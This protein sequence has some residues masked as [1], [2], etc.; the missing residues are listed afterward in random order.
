MS[1][2]SEQR[3][4][5]TLLTNQIR[6]K[7]ISTSSLAKMSEERVKRFK[8]RS[9]KER[10]DSIKIEP[11]RKL[12]KRAFDEAETSHLLA[13][14]ERGREFNKS[15]IYTGFV[16]SIEPISQSLV[17]ILHHKKKIFQ[18]FVTSISKHDV[19]SLEPLLEALA[20]FCHDLGP[21]F[22]EFYEDAILLIKEAALN[23]TEPTA[24]EAEFNCLAFIFKYLSRFLS[25]DLLQTFRLLFPLFGAK[26]HVCRFTAEA[27][28]FLIRKSSP[29][30]LKKVTSYAFESLKEDS[31]TMK[32]VVICYSEAISTTQ[33]SIHSKSESIIQCLLDQ[34]DESYA[35]GVLGDV[36]VQVIAHAS[37]E[38]V[39]DLYTLVL[40]NALA[41]LRDDREFFRSYLQILL[42]LMF[43]ESGAKITDWAVVTPYV[44]VI[45]E[46]SDIPDNTKELIVEVL[47]VFIRNCSSE[48]LMMF[49]SHLY[50]FAAAQLGHHFL[51][52]IKT[53]F[54][55]SEEK[56]K[57]FSGPYLQD[58]INKNHSK[59]GEHISLFIRDF[60]NSG[61][62][63]RSE[64]IGE[65]HVFFPS[66]STDLLFKE[67]DDL[68][69]QSSKDLYQ[70]YWRMVIISYAGA[71]NSNSLRNLLSK[72]DSFED[73]CQLKKHVLSQIIVSLEDIDVVNKY[74]TTLYTSLV[75]LRG[76]P[77]S[78]ELTE[79]YVLLFSSNLLSSDHNL[80]L[81][82][83]NVLRRFDV[84]PSLSDIIGKCAIIEEI[85]V[86][87]NTARDIQT[88]L[89]NLFTT[90]KNLDDKTTL[91]T[92][93]LYKFVFGLLSSKFSPI[94]QSIF[95]C[96]PV[97]DNYNQELLWSIIRVFIADDRETVDFAG[98]IADKESSTDSEFFSSDKRL[99]GIVDSVRNSISFYSDRQSSLLA[100]AEEQYGVKEYPQFMRGH[101]FKALR[102]LTRVADKFQKDVVSLLLDS[103]SN[104]TGSAVDADEDVDMDAAA[105][106]D[107]DIETPQSLVTA[108]SKGSKIYGKHLIE[109]LDLF[110]AW[111]KL[112]K[113]DR[114]DEIFKK[115]L[116][117]LSFKDLGVR[118]AALNVIFNFHNPAV[119]KFKDNL[120]NMLD[121]ITFRD[122]ITKLLSNNE[123][124]SIGVEDNDVVM[125]IVLRLLLGKI[126]TNDTSGH[127]K[128]FKAS[129]ILV[130][131]HLRASYIEKF[132]DIMSEAVDF[133]ERLD[134]IGP[135]SDGYLR[136]ATAYSR[137]LTKVIDTLGEKFKGT[138]LRIINPLLCTLLSAQASI[139][140]EEA[141]EED[142]VVSQTLARNVRQ[143][144]FKN[145]A[146]LFNL[147]SDFSW[148]K[149]FVVIY[150]KLLEPR[151]ASFEDENLQQ[152]TSL[153]SIITSWAKYKSYHELL[154][155][156]DLQPA[157]NAL[158]L[159]ANVNTKPAVL[160][161]VITF[162]LD[163]VKKINGKSAKYKDLVSLVSKTGF[164]HLPD[165][166]RNSSDLKVNV[167]CIE[168]LL[169]L[170]NQGYVDSQLRRTE[171][172]ALCTQLLE[173]P[174][175]QLSKDSRLQIFAL[176]K[177]LV[178]DFEGEFGEIQELWDTSSKHLKTLSDRF[179][180][181]QLIELFMEFG[182]KFSE[183]SEISKLIVNLNAFSARGMNEF[184][185]DVRLEAY[186][187]INDTRYA[188]LALF[189][190][191]PLLNNAL[192]FVSAETDLSIRG[193]A[194]YTLRRFVD[195]VNSNA[196]LLPPFKTL[197]LP[198]LRTNLR[199]KSE[200]VQTEYILLLSH[201]VKTITVLDD[202]ADMKVLLC[203]GDEEANFFNNINHIQLYRRQEAVTKLGQL[204]SQINGASVAHYILPMIEHYAYVEDEKFRNIGNDTIAAIEKLI[205]RVTYKQY[206]AIF[207]RYLSGLKETSATIRDSVKLVVTLSKAF[208]VNIKSPGDT[209]AGLPKDQ[210]KLSS[211]VELDMITPLSTVLNKR[212][213]ET[214]VQRTPLIE[215]LAS[216]IMCLSHEH[217]VSILPGTLTSICQILRSRADSIREAVRKH[218]ARASNIVGPKYTR[219]IIS[220]LKT[221]LARGF[222]VHVLGFTVHTILASMEFNHGDLDESADLLMYI[223]M[224]NLF[225]STGKEKEADGYKTTM[226]E[227]K[228]N[229]SNDIAEILVRHISLNKFESILRPLKMI[230]KERI[231]S[232]IQAKIDELIRRISLGL[233]KNDQLAD[234]DMLV[235]CY[236]I[237]ADSEAKIFEKKR[238]EFTESEMHFMVQLDAKPQMVV[239]E[240]KIH[241]EVMQRLSLDLLRTTLSKNEK[242]VNVSDLRG[243][244]PFFDIGLNSESEPV[245]ISVLRVLGFVI[246]LQF[247]DQ[248]DIFKTAARKCLNIIKGSPSTDSELVQACYKYLSS[249]LR[250]RE[251]LA[252]K[253]S[254]LGYLLVRIQS[255][256]N[257]TNKQGIAFN[258]IKA[259][260]SKHVM[261]PEVYD[262]MD[263]IREVMVTS[264]SKERRDTSRSIYYQFIMEY[265]QG[266]GRLE[267]QFTFLVD[268]L[269]YPAEA[270]KQSVMEFIHLILQK[271]GA[272]LLKTLSSSFFVGL[273]KVLISDTTARTKE[274]AV[275]L[276]TVIFE[277]QGMESFDKYISGWMNS[278]NSAL[279]RCSLQLYGIRL[280]SCGL[281]NKEL[282]DD[283]IDH[284]REVLE[285]SKNSSEVAVPWE[286]LY[287]VLNCL[288]S[289]LKIDASVVDEELLEDLISVLLFPHS[290]IRLSGNRLINVLMAKEGVLSSSNIQ[291]IAYRMFHQMRAPGCDKALTAEAIKFLMRSVLFWEAGSVEFD[292]SLNGSGEA[293]D[294]AEEEAE[295]E[296][297]EQSNLMMTEW[298]MNHASK[299]IR[300]HRSSQ[301]AKYSSIQLLAMAIQSLPLER[302]SELSETF[303][304]AL[305]AI[306]ENM[307]ENDDAD[308]IEL[309]N[310]AIECLK[311]LEDK[312][313]ISA[314]T[315]S[316]ANVRAEINKTRQERR[317]KR[318]RLAI[319]APDVAAR[320]R[321]RKNE[322][323]K[324]K[325]KH[326]KD[327]N[328]F[329]HTKK[330]RT[331][332]R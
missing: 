197:L 52:F 319:T 246:D 217:I 11:T 127:K 316:Y 302:L 67:L 15:A 249:I 63:S 92:N 161:Q 135:P 32:G 151:F 264:H 216:F 43:A 166:L 120:S 139:V 148:D 331:L 285:S 150:E 280:K 268:N 188:D 203:E 33:G 311:L 157:R 182:N 169:T 317:T 48:V 65:L 253:E 131:T 93:V 186:R 283:V 35:A 1:T 195:V 37:V 219:F 178:K 101:A 89:R 102:I 328:G 143:A 159:I 14:V 271:A 222:Q 192:F 250:H 45:F 306:H 167:N 62:L 240:T 322:K 258:F 307:K 83:L 133:T 118:K 122:E 290:W 298:A 44:E 141:A 189:E 164:D 47:T 312:V 12:Q 206:M 16:D 223:V 49:H 179:Q 213:E 134:D 58:F 214:I 323:A 332:R 273:A 221:A 256:I 193:N 114:S 277:K 155:I 303:I 191:M 145:L 220:E 181:Q 117:Y 23:T 227:V 279:L 299:I 183:C 296:D 111:K 325:R 294:E 248:V 97:V 233:L 232:K 241:T 2:G 158:L 59:Y 84:D 6:H 162:C 66:S 318:A 100:D 94:W 103:D 19:L 69:V 40:K 82:T 218:L 286:L 160:N 196:T 313:G 107:D 171:L 225:G 75:F 55:F 254:S 121:D 301:G 215:A 80:R 106:E 305:Y 198:T 74:S 29:E 3:D 201:I 276:I 77:Q 154:L 153:L 95:E 140:A 252:L 109:L 85:P 31:S 263:K 275:S 34:L 265:D 30:E 116:S 284:I 326:E 176:L 60:E 308:F 212:N 244:L 163:V 115:C 125:D 207:K 146:L 289:I 236:E 168:L 330:K 329:Y 257:S 300:S 297:K 291:N 210:V 76:L 41:K 73:E 10:L 235:L 53:T 99:N 26:D 320:K 295:D 123:E 287:S 79:D 267:N 86:T 8:H 281:T 272:Q 177:S 309:H 314:Y 266:R 165:V 229:R 327:E 27:L 208:L 230:L 152:V 130:L 255:D 46:F 185:Y 9:F 187:K 96:L 209:F 119:E 199:A 110:A 226:K 174:A 22:M 17:Q 71:K 142:D 251:D 129:S 321:S 51:A 25:R 175:A 13:S 81:A 98:F 149:Y 126:Q 184:D 72:V 20:Q 239:N 274:M 247:E 173:K 64:R 205:G 7:L 24:I 242:F 108:T 104:V 231:T 238:K 87:F 269:G 270:G 245:I 278:K 292:A 324:E 28:S 78:F 170:V 42:T 288:S 282:N 315:Q 138:L 113:V 88:R 57:K 137:T 136:M 36:L 293:E 39:K 144:G 132:L 204:A 70:V 147:L 112:K 56:S 18:L 156:N 194:S 310:I 234:H 128:G 5:L 224:E 124:S 68:E 237:F 228:N 4:E 200:E 211:Q 180:R 260:V 172:I 261:I 38:A 304:L 105:D 90:F 61:F 21:D 262:T 190:W 50:K 202:F 259:L 91:V 54:G 243:F